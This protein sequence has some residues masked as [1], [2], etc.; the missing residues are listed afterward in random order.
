MDRPHGLRSCN[1]ALQHSNVCSIYKKLPS[2]L[3]RTVYA[4]SLTHRRVFLEKQRQLT[5]PVYLI[6][7]TS[8][9]ESEIYICH[10]IHVNHFSYF[11]LL[12]LWLFYAF[13]CVCVFLHNFY[14]SSSW[15]IAFQSE[16]KLVF[17]YIRKYSFYIRKYSF[18]I[19]NFLFQK[20]VCNIRNSLF[21]IRISISNRT[22]CKNKMT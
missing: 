15:C 3:K 17:C 18:Y 12:Q 4:C 1:I 9:E 5:L 6:Y 11:L 8:F 14:L 22:S 20:V 7:N 21:Y 2:E 10:L 19:I 16:Q 13:L